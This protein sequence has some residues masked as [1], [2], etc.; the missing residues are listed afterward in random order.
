MFT[1]Q[2]LLLALFTQRE[3][4]KMRRFV[5]M[6]S[7]QSNTKGVKNELIFQLIL[8]FVVLVFDAYDRRHPRIEFH[9]VLFFSNH[10]LGA[11]VIN[12]VLLSRYLYPKK[13]LQFFIFSI[14][15]IFV[16]MLIEEAVL[17][18]IYFPETRGRDTWRG[19]FGS[20]VIYTIMDILPPVFILCGFKFAWDALTKQKEVETLKSAVRE[21][22]LQFL[23]SQI[24]PH[25]LFNNLNNLYSYAIKNAPETPQIIL[26]LSELLRYMLYDCKVPSV[27][28]TREIEQLNNF[29]NLSKLQIQGRGHVNFQSKGNLKTYQIAPLILIIFLENAF[30]H[31]T[32]SQSDQIEID[33]DLS[34]D[35]SGEMQFT[36]SNTYEED[37][38]ADQLAGGIGLENVQTRLGLLY[39]DA[40]Q[41]NMSKAD[42]KYKVTLILDLKQTPES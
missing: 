17:E 14:L 8:H 22:E 26:E 3:V 30:K 35:D 2:F 15:T 16:V 27:A 13:Y 42:G 29:I 24:N 18:R 4:V 23:K 20:G 41:L 6:E 28:L 31:S 7:R 12:Y 5:E 39:P 1:W 33:I 37:S 11:L 9:E 34:V 36:C 21:S 32:S 25:F 19:L 38:N 40:H 10:A